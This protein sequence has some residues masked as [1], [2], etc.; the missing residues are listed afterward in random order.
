MFPKQAPH[1][2]QQ[3]VSVLRIIPNALGCWLCLTFNLSTGELVWKKEK[4]LMGALAE[5]LAA[6]CLS[7]NHSMLQPSAQDEQAKNVLFNFF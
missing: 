4:R 5:V 6:P 7:L 3:R 2:C 1:S